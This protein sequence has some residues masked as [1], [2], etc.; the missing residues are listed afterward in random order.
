MPLGPYRGVPRTP[1]SSLPSGFSCDH[2]PGT[3]F[4][5]ALASGRSGPWR[6]GRP[7]RHGTTSRCLWS[8]GPLSLLSFTL[9][10]SGFRKLSP[11]QGPAA[12]HSR[13]P[14]GAGIQWTMELSGPVSVVSKPGGTLGRAP[15]GSPC[16]GVISSCKVSQMPSPWAAICGG[17]SRPPHG[18]R[19][20]LPT[21]YRGCVTLRRTLTRPSGPPIRQLQLSGNQR[22]RAGARSPGAD[23]D[24]AGVLH[25]HLP[26]GDVHRPWRRA[27]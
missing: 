7:D 2:L 19:K 1:G 3:G 8:A 11:G 26:A 18:A 5:A 10:S 22:R 24:R 4:V 27:G 16:D 13:P 21:R 12:K 17:V 25:H 20:I 6:S 9:S 14:G 23:G 15:P